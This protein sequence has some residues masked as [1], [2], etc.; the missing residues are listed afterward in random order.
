M[1]LEALRAK[2][3]QLKANV[4]QL[5]EKAKSGGNTTPSNA[6]YEILEYAENGY[7]KKVKYQIPQ[8][9]DETIV[10]TYAF[11]N[12]TSSNSLFSRNIEE[13]EIPDTVTALANKA[14][15]NCRSLKS[16]TNY[17]NI[18]SIGECGLS[19][20]GKEFL[21]DHLPPNI[22]TISNQAFDSTLTGRSILIFPASVKTVG[23]RAFYGCAITNVI[24]RGTPE[25]LSDAFTAVRS[26]SNIYVPWAEGEVE[27]APWGATNA[28]I[29]YNAEV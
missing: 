13:V 20:M 29:H 14:F 3:E 5:I 1:S 24:F 6:I 10:P 23:S 22:E 21:I 18:I 11:G 8:G 19:T 2:F 12:Y 4:E 27:G 28:T 17:D 25:T 26:L 7:P 16:I 9:L 15:F